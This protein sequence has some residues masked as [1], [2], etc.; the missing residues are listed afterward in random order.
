MTCD[1]CPKLDVSLFLSNCYR[2]QLA[3]A[4]SGDCGYKLNVEST[5]V[6]NAKALV[7]GGVKVTKK[8]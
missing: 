7:L 4:P 8:P 2:R 1:K 3:T 5:K 6:G